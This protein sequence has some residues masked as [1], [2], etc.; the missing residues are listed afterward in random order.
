MEA[1]HNLAVTMGKKMDAMMSTLSDIKKKQD[2]LALELKQ[3]CPPTPVTAEPR[4]LSVC[5][6]TC[7]TP[8][9]DPS[10]YKSDSF[11]NHTPKAGAKPAFKVSTTTCSEAAFTLP[12]LLHSPCQPQF[13]LYCS[14]G[15]SLSDHSHFDKGSIQDYLY[16]SDGGSLSDHSHFNQGSIQDH[17][18]CSQGLS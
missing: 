15:G 14:D 17:P 5:F 16:C 9:M 12:Y 13:H 11:T 18:R 2:H 8:A 6:P 3:V 1:I 4:Q 7:S 10:W